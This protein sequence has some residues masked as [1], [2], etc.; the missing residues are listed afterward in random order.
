G[1][2]ALGR[3]PWLILVEQLPIADFRVHQAGTTGDEAGAN[4]HKRQSCQIRGAR[5]GA[6]HGT[7]QSTTQ[8]AFLPA[9]LVSSSRVEC[10]RFRF[11]GNVIALRLTSVSKVQG[12]RRARQ[13]VSPF[14]PIPPPHLYTK[15]NT[16]ISYCGAIIM[17]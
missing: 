16:V 8:L 10:Q 12:P 14:S 13:R 17:E 1:S 5:T 9:A 4:G 7:K 2:E 3:I 15:D 11:Q 6:P